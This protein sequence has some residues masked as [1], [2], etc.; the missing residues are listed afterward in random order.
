[1]SVTPTLCSTQYSMENDQYP[2]SITAAIDIL[3][4]HK[5]DNYS[6][7]KDEKYK[8]Q[9]EDGNKSTASETSFAQFSGVTC[10]CCGKKGHKSPQCP[11][12]D[13][14]P[15]DQWAIRRAEQHLQA[16]ADGDDDDDGSIASHAT[17]G[18]NRSFQNKGWSGLQVNLM[19]HEDNQSMRESISLDNGS[20]LSLF[21]NP[22]LVKDIRQS[23]TTLKMHT[24]AGSKESNQQVTM[25]GFGNVWFH[26]DAIANIF[27]FGDLV[28]KYRITYDSEMEDAFLVH[29]EHKTVNLQEPLKDYINLKFHKHTKKN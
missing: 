11:E 12:K 4:N 25:P 1:M 21:C 3:A 23:N 15:R 28:S 18:T 19:N 10:Y 29:M 14:R 22:E 13:T 9:D 2:I 26:E 16:E 5:H 20:T 27:G 24:K 6:L 17:S 7:K 8:K